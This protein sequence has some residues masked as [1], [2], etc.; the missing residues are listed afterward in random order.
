MDSCEVYKTTTEKIHL[1]LTKAFK[2]TWGKLKGAET[3][4]RPV[5]KISASEEEKMKEPMGELFGMMSK[6]YESGDSDMK[7][8]IAR[9]WA[10]AE[11]KHKLESTN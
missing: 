2:L 7:Q 3:K 4:L 10:T 6:L 8:H 5:H 9:A 1:R 11:E